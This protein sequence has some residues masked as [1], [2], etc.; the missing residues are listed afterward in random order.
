MKLE[1]LRDLLERL[2]DTYQATDVD[3]SDPA[4]EKLASDPALKVKNSLFMSI[5]EYGRAVHAEMAVITDAARRGVPLQDA[6]MY[7]TTFPCHNCAKNI[8]AAGVKEVVYIEPYPK[9]QVERLFS[10][11]IAM[12]RQSAGKVR[13]LPF[14]GIAPH[15]FSDFFE[16]TDRK[17]TQGK[18][19]KWDDMRMSSRP[20]VPSDPASY[21][22]L[23]NDKVKKDLGTALADASIQ[24]IAGS[25]E[26]SG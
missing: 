8:V 18:V 2:P 3:L 7:G 6:V 21:I 16:I 5:T 22:P 25:G 4:I 26:E 9:S 24:F 23:E 11:S 13:F 17:G 19:R 15:R 20:R 12:D 1:I 14:V 10:D